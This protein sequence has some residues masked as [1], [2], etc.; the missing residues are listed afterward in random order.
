MTATL[1]HV[2]LNL[3][4]EDLPVGRL[5]TDYENG[6]ESAS[7]KYAESYLKSPRAFALGPGL[8]LT[9]ATAHTDRQKCIFASFTDCAPGRWG[10]ML[11]REFEDS[12]P[13]MENR[14]GGRLNEADY[15]FMVNDCLRQGALRFKEDPAA[16]FWAVGDQAVPS[17]EDL[18]ALLKA[19]DRLLNDEAHFADLEK[20]LIPGTALGGARPKICVRDENGKLCLAKFPKAADRFDNVRWE[21]VALT[22]AE[23]A[24]LKVQKWRLINVAG[25]PVLLLERFDRRGEKRIPFISALCMLNA[26]DGDSGKYSYLHIAD[27][28]RTQGVRVRDDLREMWSRILFSVLIS[29]TDDH[30][31]NHGFLK[32]DPEGWSLSPL[33]DVNPGCERTDFLQ[34]KIDET[35]SKVCLELPLSVAAYFGLSAKEAQE[36]LSRQLAA[37]SGWQDTA[38]ALG[39]KGREIARMSAAFRL[40]SEKA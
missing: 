36:I 16:D 29:N 40:C 8:P 34:L 1:T 6:R 21:A 31:R 7:F 18:P 28:I 15:L 9:E 13:Q 27:I 37:V 12:R 3:E 38:R 17:L 23:K 30:L 14:P 26:N 11:I 25:R 35:G 10:R 19:S 5:W 24:G 2:Y 33:F 39:I 4:G 22:L 20:L 32:L